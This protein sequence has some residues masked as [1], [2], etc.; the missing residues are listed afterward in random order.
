MRWISCESLDNVMGN[1]AKKT[2]INLTV[3]LPKDI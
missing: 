3:P 2:P 1:L